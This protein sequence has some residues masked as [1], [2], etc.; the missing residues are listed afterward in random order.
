MTG[1]IVLFK[2]SRLMSSDKSEKKDIFSSTGEEKTPD[3]NKPAVTE[4]PKTDLQE[5]A[6]SI[7]AGESPS[8]DIPV[9]SSPPVDASVN[10]PPAEGLAGLP[11]PESI[12]SPSADDEL[13]FGGGSELEGAFDNKNTKEGKSSNENGENNQETVSENLSHS[14]APGKST[15]N[16][17]SGGDGPLSSFRDIFKEKRKLIII[18][19]VVGLALPLMFFLVKKFILKPKVA[20][21]KVVTLNYWGLWEPDQVMQGLI[22]QF[23]K[24]NPGIKINYRFSSKQEYKARLQNSLLK[25]QGPDIF[26]FHQSWLPV[27]KSQLA[28]VPPST[29][30]ALGLDKDYFAIVPRS[31]KI[32]NRF[33]A[34]PLMVDNLAL[35]YNKPLLKLTGQQPPRTWW[36]L[37]EVAKKV[38][39]RDEAGRIKIA[40]AALGTTGNVDHWS[41]V[42]GLML[43]QN[44]VD[45]AHMENDRQSIEDV[46]RFYTL[47]Y[48]RDHVW[49][50]TLP[51]STLAFA[52]NKLV[53]YFAPSWRIFDLLAINPNLDF[54]VVPAPKLPNNPN[55]D[56]KT[57]EK[58]GEELAQINWSSFW[59][60]GVWSQSSHKDEAWKFLEFLASKKSL[61][62]FYETASQVREFGEIYPVKS[63]AQDL[64]SNPHLSAFVDQADTSYSWYLSS[65]TYDDGPNDVMINYFADAINAISQGEDPKIT[66][67]TLLQGVAQVKS[68]YKLP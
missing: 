26:R 41:D 12:K 25:K 22:S 37:Q 59:A 20:P 18:G 51:S 58:G 14:G 33:W 35:F 19:L 46:L 36:G 6:R 9:D 52:T 4:Q 17:G 63:L 11:V 40:G 67:E 48:S 44:G 45:L 15:D 49:D 13:S 47:F 16:Q 61:R 43:V 66:V 60:E 29:V 28:P 24:E 8:V 23:E 62:Q 5:T 1:K 55:A 65:D 38:T 2:K 31:L 32:D 68:R 64:K 27:F 54:A 7:P 10:R 39:T 50:S 30:N 53:F 57:V 34:V 3:F 21:N 56:L 42:V